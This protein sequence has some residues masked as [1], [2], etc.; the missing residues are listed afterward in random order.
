MNVRFV[1]PLRQLDTIGLV[2]E[3]GEQAN[4]WQQRGESSVHGAGTRLCRHSSHA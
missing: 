3:S 4:A 2:E 1:K